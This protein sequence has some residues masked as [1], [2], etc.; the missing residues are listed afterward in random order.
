MGARQVWGSGFQDISVCSIF[1]VRVFDF[2]VGISTSHLFH[3][4]LATSSVASKWTFYRTPSCLA[5]SVSAKTHTD[6]DRHRHRHRHWHR[7][8]LSTQTQT[9][10]HT[11]CFLRRRRFFFSSSSWIIWKNLK[12]G[13]MLLLVSRKDG[14]LMEHTQIRRT[15]YR[16]WQSRTAI[17]GGVSW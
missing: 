6:T 9:R 15:K 17:V 5:F 10:I 7:H 13:M 2:F 16:M 3:S 12:E 1:L 11:H 4:K 14:E 8:R